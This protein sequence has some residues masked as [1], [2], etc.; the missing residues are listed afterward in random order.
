MEKYKICPACQHRN[1][2]FLLE[3]EECETDLQSAP[4]MD[5]ATEQ[6]AAQP[7]PAATP[8]A[9]MVRLCDCGA[10][11]PVQARRCSVCGEDISVIAP[12]PD[13]AATEQMRYILSSLDGAFAFEIPQGVTCIGR[14]QEMAGYLADKP[15]VSRKHAMLI[16]DTTAATLTIQNL[17]ATNFTF[18]NN[19]ML[20]GDMSAQLQDGDEIGLGGH[21]QNGSRQPEAAYFLVRIGTCI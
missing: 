2:P 8:A 3:C 14:E 9:A 5:A 21:G 20:S 12:T 10:K 11:N 17:S 13:T 4:V 7:A 19:R 15:F 6:A 16:L 1:A 18:V